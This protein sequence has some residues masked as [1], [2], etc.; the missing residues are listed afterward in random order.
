MLLIIINYHAKFGQF[1]R[2]ALRGAY[3]MG[4]HKADPQKFEPSISR[5][6][7]LEL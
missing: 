1:G 4:V 5:L 6:R 2:C 3:G 7:V